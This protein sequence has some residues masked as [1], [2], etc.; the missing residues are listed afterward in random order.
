MDTVRSTTVDI[1]FLFK[2]NYYGSVSWSTIVD[3]H[4]FLKQ[5]TF[6]SFLF[7]STTVDIY[8]FLKHLMAHWN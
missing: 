3:I 5:Y 7:Q 8:S 1:Y 4:F 2:L 6:S